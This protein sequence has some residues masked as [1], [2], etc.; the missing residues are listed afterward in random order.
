MCDKTFFFRE[1]YK[2]GGVKAFDRYSLGRKGF[3]KERIVVRGKEQ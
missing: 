1:K 3:S 2:S